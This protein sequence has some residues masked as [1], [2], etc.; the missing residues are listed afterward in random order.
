MLGFRRQRGSDRFA[1]RHY[2]PGQWVH[3]R[4]TL[5][6]WKTSLCL[7]AQTTITQF[8]LAL[9]LELNLYVC[10]RPERLAAQL[11]DK[12]YLSNLL[13]SEPWLCSWLYGSFQKFCLMLHR[14][15]ESSLCPLICI[16]YC[17]CGVLKLAVSL[18]LVQQQKNYNQVIV[19]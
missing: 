1:D 16:N 6:A 9:S 12:R 8:Y 7:L 4:Y 19:R 15:N 18:L 10:E 3:I 17:L 2:L 13:C 11:M 14:H 5:S